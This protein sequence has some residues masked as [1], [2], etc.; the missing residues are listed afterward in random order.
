MLSCRSRRM[1]GSRRRLSTRGMRQ[2]MTGYR[3]PLLVSPCPEATEYMHL[4]PQEAGWDFL[5]FGARKMRCGERWQH[6]TGDREVAL[7]LLGGVCSVT[8]NRGE[9][10]RIGRRP[11][12]F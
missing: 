11:N 6:A 7:A 8:S 10:S 1:T 3:S 9:W 12:V 2:L 4:T 5:H